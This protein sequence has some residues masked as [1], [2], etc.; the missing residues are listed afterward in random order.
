MDHYNVNGIR[1]F[2]VGFNLKFMNF[3][4]QSFFYVHTYHYLETLNE[5]DL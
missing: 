1:I 2:F 4:L 3:V 5:K